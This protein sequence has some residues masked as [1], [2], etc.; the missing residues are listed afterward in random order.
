LLGPNLKAGS[1]RSPSLT[2]DIVAG[3]P[4]SILLLQHTTI[5]YSESIWIIKN[6]VITLVH[7]VP[8]DT[9]K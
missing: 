9:Y 1:G 7:P 4:G 5:Q 6:P 3:L 8:G 2:G